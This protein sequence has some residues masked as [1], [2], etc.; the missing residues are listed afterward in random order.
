MG[1]TPHNDRPEECRDG[2][3]VHECEGSGCRF[4][5]DEAHPVRVPPVPGTLIVEVPFTK[6]EGRHVRRNT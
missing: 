6:K 2:C 1:L 4:L 3:Q 5:H